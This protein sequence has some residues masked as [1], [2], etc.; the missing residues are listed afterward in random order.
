MP[1]TDVLE[2]RCQYIADLFE[3]SIA[4]A[5]DNI[6]IRNVAEK[7]VLALNEKQDLPYL[8]HDLESVSSVYTRRHYMEPQISRP[9]CIWFHG[10]PEFSVFAV[11]NQLSEL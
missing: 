8:I 3:W 10:G 11:G 1:S 7:S 2:R 4:T 9:T 6:L 5:K